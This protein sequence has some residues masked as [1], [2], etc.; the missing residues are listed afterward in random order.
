[1]KLCSTGLN[2]CNLGYGVSVHRIGH[3]CH[4]KHGEHQK[5]LYKWYGDRVERAE[6]RK[7]TEP[8]TGEMI[9]PGPPFPPKVPPNG[10]RA[11][12][13]PLPPKMP[14]LFHSGNKRPFKLCSKSVSNYQNQL[15]EA[16]KLFKKSHI[17]AWFHC[18]HIASLPK[19]ITHSWVCV[20]ASLSQT[21]ASLTDVKTNCVLHLRAYLAA[22][23]TDPPEFYIARWGT[24]CMWV[25][26]EQHTPFSATAARGSSP[27]HGA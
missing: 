26:H 7:P 19:V 20:I 14:I 3:R 8:A 24:V 15:V 27:L 5:K 18:T 16:E 4:G 1:M 25:A 22:L 6:S 12:F 17:F 2:A 21:A 23:P 13:P 11:I 9:F 10:G